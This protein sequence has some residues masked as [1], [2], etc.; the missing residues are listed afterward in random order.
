MIIPNNP[1]YHMLLG[2]IQM[3]QTTNQNSLGFRT[4]WA[5]A[6]SP[7]AVAAAHPPPPPRPLWPW[8]TR[9]EGARRRR[10]GEKNDGKLMDQGILLGFYGFLWDFVGFLLGFCW[11]CLWD[12]M[13]YIMGYNRKYGSRSVVVNKLCLPCAHHVP[14]MCWSNL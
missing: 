6:T 13:G 12:F 3:F 14:I 9:R 10:P 2:I 11:F 5:A 1:I 7:A 8:G 4:P